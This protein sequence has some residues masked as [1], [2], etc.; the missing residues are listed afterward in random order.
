MPTVAPFKDDDTVGKRQHCV[1]SWIVLG[2]SPGRLVHKEEANQIGLCWVRYNLEPFFL[3]DS[4]L[5]ACTQQILK[6][7]G[8]DSDRVH[9]SH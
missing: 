2:K 3:P 4:V 9:Q 8:F 7:I 1:L 5:S 6:S